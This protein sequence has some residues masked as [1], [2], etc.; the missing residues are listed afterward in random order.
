[1][2]EA[3]PP[4]AWKRRLH[5]HKAPILANSIYGIDGIEYVVHLLWYMAY[6]GWYMVYGVDFIGVQ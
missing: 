4:T 2:A 1:M 3:S 5:K 6:S